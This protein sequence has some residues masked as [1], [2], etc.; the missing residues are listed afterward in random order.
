MP[1]PCD[2]REGGEPTLNND[3]Y[4]CHQKVRC[5]PNE[6]QP[7]QPMQNADPNLQKNHHGIGAYARSKK[8]PVPHI[9]CFTLCSTNTKR[10]MNYE[11]VANLHVDFTPRCLTQALVI[12]S[13]AHSGEANIVLQ[14]LGLEDF[15]L[16]V[17]WF[18]FL[19]E[20]STCYPKLTFPLGIEKLAFLLLLPCHS[21]CFSQWESIP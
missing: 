7:N 21:S 8:W 10:D 5:H 19:V 3:N 12:D 14:F 13:S 16:Y 2:M 4:S 17:S 1:L 9:P 6:I 18:F 20:G 15:D 11:N